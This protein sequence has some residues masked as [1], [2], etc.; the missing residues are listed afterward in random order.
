MRRMLPVLIALIASPAAAQFVGK[1]VYEPV[2][3]PSPSRHDSA[4]PPPLVGR[5]LRDIRGRID[6][7]HDAG[8]LDRRDARGLDREARRIGRLT[9]RYGRDG[10][11]GSERAEI[12][13]RILALREAVNRPRPTSTPRPR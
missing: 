6:R 2:S 8:D 4:L 10:L 5:E 11:S 9:N 13:T 1:P 7:A 12:Q 3:I